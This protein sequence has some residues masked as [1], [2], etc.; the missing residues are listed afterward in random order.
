MR[1]HPSP[2]TNRLRIVT[3]QYLSGRRP[4]FIGAQDS[5]DHSAPTQP[6]TT[7]FLVNE[8]LLNE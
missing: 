4:N 7:G 8:R 5:R 2:D 1:L 3:R 6:K